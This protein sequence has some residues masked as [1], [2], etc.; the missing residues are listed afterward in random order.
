MWILWQKKNFENQQEKKYK[1]D[2][3]M[4]TNQKTQ[5]DLFKFNPYQILGVTEN[6]SLNEIKQ[7]FQKLM[8]RYHPDKNDSSIADDQTI[9][10]RKA[11]EILSD[12]KK[13]Q[14]LDRQRNSG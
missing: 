9:I 8:L 10:I 2:K 11:Y 14:E 7:A 4:E 6:A 12:P 1:F 13:R 5:D 3:T